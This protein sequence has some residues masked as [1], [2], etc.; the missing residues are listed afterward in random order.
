[1]IDGLDVRN[2][3]LCLQ[4]ICIAAG[5]CVSDSKDKALFI[6]ANEYEK[7]TRNEPCAEW[8]PEPVLRRLCMF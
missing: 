8:K 4:N 3:G 7:R 6:R 2:K 1:M 5:L